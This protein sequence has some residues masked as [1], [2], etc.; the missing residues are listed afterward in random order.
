MRPTQTR[1]FGLRSLFYVTFLF[2]SASFAA[3]QVLDNPDSAIETVL[4]VS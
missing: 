4:L 3:R 1:R 2:A